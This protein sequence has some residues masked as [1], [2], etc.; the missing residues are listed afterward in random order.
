MSA[1][2]KTYRQA[3]VCRKTTETDI[4]LTIKLDGSGVYDIST[5]IGFFD[6]M[7]EQLSKHSQVDIALKC[8]G[9]LYIDAHHTVEDVGIALGDAFRDALG[10]K[11][12]IARYADTITPMDECLV[13]VAL[14]F[15][16]RSY[17][18][19]NVSLKTQ[20][21]GNLE[22]ESISEFFTAFSRSAGLT[23]HI[24]ELDGG[25]TH[26]MLEGIFKG[27]ARAIKEAIALVDVSPTADI[28]STKGTL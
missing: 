14:D 27:F 22:T 5:G 7:L 2:D 1:I 13:L 12:G 16:G 23:L 20:R 17:V 19:Y 24:K 26:H 3:R 11:R 8:L 9:D 6:H 15:S 28:P 4:D 10:D 18:N 21:L 25:N